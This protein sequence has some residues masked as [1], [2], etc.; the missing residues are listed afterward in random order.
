MDTQTWYRAQVLDHKW[1]MYFGSA[2][3]G[4]K[5]LPNGNVLVFQDTTGKEVRHGLE[6][7]IS[8]GTARKVLRTVR[9]N[10]KPVVDERGPEIDAW[11]DSY[12]APKANQVSTM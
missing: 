6:W 12:F 5:C 9:E 3:V 11:L 1:A 8:L 10:G 4:V 2:R 7:T